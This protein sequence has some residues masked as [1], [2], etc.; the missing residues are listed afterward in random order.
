MLS[1]GNSMYL[2]FFFFLMTLILPSAYLEGAYL[3][4]AP[5]GLQLLQTG[6]GRGLLLKRQTPAWATVGSVSSSDTGLS[7]L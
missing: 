4:F 7:H 6:G 2:L 1:D 5:A 3:F